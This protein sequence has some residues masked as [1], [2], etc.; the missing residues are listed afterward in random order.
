M[1][2]LC[3]RNVNLDRLNV[4]VTHGIC[5]MGGFLSKLRTHPEVDL[6][7]EA[8]VIRK[9]VRQNRGIRDVVWEVILRK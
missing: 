2:E 7:Q 8:E 5:Y 6:D 3:R 9:I 1:H 4:R